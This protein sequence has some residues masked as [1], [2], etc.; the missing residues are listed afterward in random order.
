MSTKN[1]VS[2]G[3]AET[4]MSGIKSAIDDAGGGG[5]F[6]KV[7]A[8]SITNGSTTIGEAFLSIY[9]AFSALSD[10]KKRCCFID[11]T[12]S[13]NYRIYLYNYYTGS[14][15]FATIDNASG[16]VYLGTTTAAQ[17][18]CL[19]GSVIPNSSTL[20]G[21]SITKIELCYMEYRSAVVPSGGGDTLVY[22]PASYSATVSATLTNMQLAFNELTDEQ[23]LK[24]YIVIKGDGNVGYYNHVKL[25]KFHFSAFYANTFFIWF[26][27]ASTDTYIILNPGTMYLGSS[28]AVSGS[29]TLTAV[30][31]SFIGLYTE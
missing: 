15:T 27:C 6:E 20:S 2:Y 16:K 13:V 24:S 5:G 31:I 19:A 28:S 21:T 1:F 23:K 29:A 30:G 11:V 25:A 12:G 7:V 17:S 22:E 4:L 8:T 9:N 18:V 10:E 26:Q 14:A 3:D